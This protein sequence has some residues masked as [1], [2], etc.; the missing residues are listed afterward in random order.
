[1]VAPAVRSTRLIRVPHLDCA[2]QAQVCVA[3]TSY[4]RRLRWVAGAGV[5]VWHSLTRSGLSVG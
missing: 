2:S 3:I 1:M 5:E 4:L